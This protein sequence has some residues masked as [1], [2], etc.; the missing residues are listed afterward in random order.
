MLLGAQPEIYYRGD[1]WWI[2]LEGGGA[3]VPSRVQRQSS[4][5]NLGEKPPETKCARGLYKNTRT[6]RNQQISVYHCQTI[7][8][9]KNTYYDEVGHVPIPPPP[10]HAPITVN[11]MVGPKKLQTLKTGYCFWPTQYMTWD[12][13]IAHTVSTR[14]LDLDP[15]LRSWFSAV[16]RV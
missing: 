3:E 8:Q 9:Y 7:A 11:T 12:K 2:F 16:K 6:I 5:G 14:L 10:G 15:V 13:Y 4:D 1:Y